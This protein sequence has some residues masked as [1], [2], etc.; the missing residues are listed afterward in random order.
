MQ[1][2]AAARTDAERVSSCRVWRVSSAAMTVGAGRAPRARAALIS[3]EIADRRRNDVQSAGGSTNACAAICPAR[4]YN[5]VLRYLRAGPTGCRGSAQALQ[6]ASLTGRRIAEADAAM[7]SACGPLAARRLAGRSAAAPH[8]RPAAPEQPG[9]RRATRRRAA[10]GHGDHAQRR[11]H[12]RD[13]RDQPRRAARA[14][15]P[16]ARCGPR[17]ARCR[18]RPPR[19]RSVL[20]RMDSAADTSAERTSARCSSAE[21]SLVANR[22]AGGLAEDQQCWPPAPPSGAALR[23]YSLKMRIALAAGRP[24]DAHSAPSSTPSATPAARAIAP[25]CARSCSRRCA[26]RAPRRRTRSAQQQRSDSCAAG[27]SSAPLATHGARRS[28]TSPLGCARW[29]A[30]LPES[31]CAAMCSRRHSHRRC[32][33]G[34]PAARVALLLPL[35]GPAAAQ[36]SAVRD[37]FLSASTSCRRASAAGAAA[38]RHRREPVPD[39]LAQAHAAGS[40]F[41]VGPLVR[42]NVAAVA[43]A[44][45][46]SPCRC[47]R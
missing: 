4:A 21:I 18:P 2:A 37:G 45:S 8:Y 22:A 33:H 36:A 13:T 24:L 16:A 25:H 9:Q 42:E 26:V 32:I 29:R 17:V 34:R 14:A 35:T 43:S 1:R 11:R 12:L 44:R 46:R 10:R 5:C 19:P 3:A 31:P 23:Y 40:T 27:S 6:C 15:I 28:L 20:A 38:V 7:M 47:W 30:Q 39:A 41:I